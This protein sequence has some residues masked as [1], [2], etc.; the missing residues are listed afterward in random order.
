LSYA[1]N[2]RGPRASHRPPAPERGVAMRACACCA[3]AAGAVAVLKAAC[4]QRGVVEGVKCIAMY[5]CI[6]CSAV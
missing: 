6:L 2:E 4:A 5:S 1:A 3:P